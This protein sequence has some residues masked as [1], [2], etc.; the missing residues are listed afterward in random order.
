M[1]M[2]I[3]FAILLTALGG[4]TLSAC[5]TVEGVGEDVESAGDSLEDAAQNNKNY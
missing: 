2:K 1:N 3:L 5:N 4:L